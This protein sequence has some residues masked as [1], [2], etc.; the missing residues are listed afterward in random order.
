M[1][2]ASCMGFCALVPWYGVMDRTIALTG[3]IRNGDELL[4]CL[5]IYRCIIFLLPR[6]ACL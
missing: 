5:H 2:L 1:S 4:N 6:L 3:K